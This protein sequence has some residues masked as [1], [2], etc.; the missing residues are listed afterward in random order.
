M[1][2]VDSISEDLLLLD[3]SINF[4]KKD[5]IKNILEQEIKIYIKLL[6]KS[7]DFI[8]CGNY[9][10]E[11]L[12]DEKGIPKKLIDYYFGEKYSLIDNG[13][14]SMNPIFDDVLLESDVWLRKLHS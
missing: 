4:D 5:N 9:S 2:L 12:M 8:I 7:E 6:I 1:D 13:L 14:V 10:L 11:K 3:Q